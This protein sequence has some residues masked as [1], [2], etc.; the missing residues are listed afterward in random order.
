MARVLLVDD[1]FDMREY[2]ARLLSAKYEVI[3]AANG[4]VLLPTHRGWCA[5]LLRAHRVRD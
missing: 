3:S 4:T 2:V 1:N 5:S